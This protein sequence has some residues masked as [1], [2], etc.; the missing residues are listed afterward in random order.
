MNAVS[1]GSAIPSGIDRAEYC[2]QVQKEV[3]ASD[4]LLP[5]QHLAS[6]SNAAEDKRTASPCCKQLQ[7]H[8]RRAT[9]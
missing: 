1:S 3:A 8:C 5:A 4:R 2:E 6:R 9:C 7:S